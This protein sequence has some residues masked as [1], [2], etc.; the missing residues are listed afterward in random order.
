MEVD[1]P[2]TV[3]A[4]D[5]GDPLKQS[6]GRVPKGRAPFR[7]VN[8]PLGRILTVVTALPDEGKNLNKQTW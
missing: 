1:F 7:V 6:I 4:R 8:L 3:G 5:T 2:L